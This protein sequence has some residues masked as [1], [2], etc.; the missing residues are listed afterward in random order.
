[1]SFYSRGLRYEDLCNCKEKGLPLTE[2]QEKFIRDFA[3]EQVLNL[4]EDPECAAAMDRFYE[5]KWAHR[6][7]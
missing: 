5:S 1:M 7:D 6:F 2:E 3:M 4:R